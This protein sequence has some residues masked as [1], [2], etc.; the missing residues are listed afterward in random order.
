MDLLTLA[1]C[2]IAAIGFSWP[3]MSRSAQGT[4]PAWVSFLVC[5]GAALL[6]LEE[7]LRKGSTMPT[8]ANAVRLLIAG[9][10]MLGTG[11]LVY[12]IIVAPP[13]QV[14]K[15]GPL[16]AGMMIGFLALGGVLIYGE[17]FTARTGF[18]IVA[19]M[20]GAVLLV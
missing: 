13:Y 11:T 7:I 12:A 19:I 8:P 9:I 3:L 18:G 10:A 2:I 15:T 6:A 17:P 20:I 16:T 1:L 14:S 4:D 5:G